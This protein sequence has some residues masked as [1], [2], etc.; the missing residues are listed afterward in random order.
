M[1]GFWATPREPGRLPLLSRVGGAC[2]S[3]AR[4]A[5]GLRPP[6]VLLHCHTDRA[7]I[8]TAADCGPLLLLH[9]PAAALNHGPSCGL[10]PPLV[11]LHS[12]HGLYQTRALGSRPPLVLLHSRA[13]TSIVPPA[14]D[15]GR[16]SFCYT[17]SRPTWLRSVAADCGRLS[18]C[19]TLDR[20]H[21]P[22]RHPLRI[23]A[24]SRFATLKPAAD[25][26]VGQLRIA[27]ASRFAT[28]DRPWLAFPDPLR[29][30]VAS[31]FAD[32]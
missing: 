21:S 17:G 18:F 25:I 31:R 23:A 14:A 7:L 26:I 28:L 15:C 4:T 27:A 22:Q 8:R 5:C 19:L 20:P 11:L 32:T 9:F 10:R 3:Q 6:L 1:W 13:C 12:L 30:A 2:P 29:I 24:A 16:L